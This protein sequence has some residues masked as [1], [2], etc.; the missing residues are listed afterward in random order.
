MHEQSANH[1]ALEAFFYALDA[2]G[3]VSDHVA[4]AL[5]LDPAKLGKELDSGASRSTASSSSL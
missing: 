2:R 5:A 1:L 3:R 4:R